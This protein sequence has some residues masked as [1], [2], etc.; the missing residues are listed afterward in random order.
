MVI[1]KNKYLQKLIPTCTICPNIP[2]FTHPGGAFT[3]LGGA[4][5]KIRWKNAKF[6]TIS[7]FKQC[8]TL[9]ESH[10]GIL[11]IQYDIYRY[12]THVCT[13]ILYFCSSWVVQKSLKC[14][15]SP[16]VFSIDGL[17][18]AWYVRAAENRECLRW[19]APH[20]CTCMFHICANSI[21][22]V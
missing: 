8:T 20:Y 2:I 4:F 1:L 15:I 16:R 5:R 21:I 9:D 13:V 14:A 22:T 6:V 17:P 19:K 7:C 11:S 18:A 12:Y 10:F 3:H